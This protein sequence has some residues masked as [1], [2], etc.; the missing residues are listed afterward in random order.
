MVFRKTRQLVDLREITVFPIGFFWEFEVKS[1]VY[2][3]M[4]KCLIYSDPQSGRSSPV[5][6][7]LEHKV[8]AP[9]MYSLLNV[10]TTQQRPQESLSGRKYQ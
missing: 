9:E 2:L 10:R 8:C 6:H 7:Q 4:D 5:T 1:C 3:A